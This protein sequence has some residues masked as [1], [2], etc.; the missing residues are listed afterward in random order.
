M[1]NGVVPRRFLS[2]TWRTCCCWA[3]QHIFLPH[4]SVLD[5]KRM[6]RMTRMTSYCRCFRCSLH[7]LCI[8]IMT[9]E[10][11]QQVRGKRVC[12]DQNSWNCMELLRSK[13]AMYY[14]YFTFFMKMEKDKKGM[15]RQPSKH[16][17][18]PSA[19]TVLRKENARDV[20]TGHWNDS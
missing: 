1:Q 18:N 6:T 19:R 14:M 13:C 2:S 16:Q 3:G 9:A 7:Q 12:Q 17:K 8:R 11:C 10:T 20:S 4:G 15:L 5:V